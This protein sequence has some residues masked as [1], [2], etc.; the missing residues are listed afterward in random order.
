MRFQRQGHQV[1][2]RFNRPSEHR[3]GRKKREKL[4]RRE[5]AFAGKPN[6]REQTN[7]KSEVRNPDQPEPERR[8]GVSFDHFQLTARCRSIRETRQCI[9]AAPERTQ[10]ADAVNGL[11]DRR[12]DIAPLVLGGP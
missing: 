10:N 7:R 9:R 3:C 2:N 4:S 11:F 8:F 5:I 6:A 1:P 12:G